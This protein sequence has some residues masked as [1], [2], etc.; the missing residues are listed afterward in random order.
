MLRSQLHNINET[1]AQLKRNRVHL[2]GTISHY[3]ADSQHQ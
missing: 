1:L 2:E 3:E